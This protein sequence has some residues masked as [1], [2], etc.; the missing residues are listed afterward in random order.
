MARSGRPCA[1]TVLLRH[2]S[3]RPRKHFY[4]AAPM[5]RRPKALGAKSRA[6]RCQS[7]CN[8]L[9]CCP[10]QR[11]LCCCA[12]A[13]GERPMKYFYPAAPTQRRPKALGAKPGAG[14]CHSHCNGFRC[15]RASAQT[16]MLPVCR[17]FSDLQHRPVVAVVA[18]SLRA[19]AA[20]HAA[21]VTVSPNDSRLASPSF[22][23]VEALA[24]NGGGLKLIVLYI[25]VP[26][27]SRLRNTAY[28]RLCTA[29]V[30][31]HRATT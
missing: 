5:Q 28:T 13:A 1:E 25:H 3:R 10:C 7:H 4:L 9:R 31:Y 2:C 26:S 14:R 29:S 24:S 23:A 8:G 21:A 6:G 27:C 15:C 17:R 20:T 19:S 30:R 12:N 16:V 18:R 11:K 22:K